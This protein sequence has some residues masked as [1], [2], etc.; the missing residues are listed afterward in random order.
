MLKAFRHILFISIMLAFGAGL[1][2]QDLPT[3]GQQA[4]ITT[5]RFANGISYYIVPNNNSKGYANFALVQKGVENQDDARAAL[6]CS[7]LASKGVGYTRLGFITYKGGAAVYNFEDVPTFQSVALDSTIIQLFNLIGA[8]KNEQAIVACGDI[9]AAKLKDR[10]YMMSLTVAKRSAPEALKP[11]VWQPS[12]TPRFIQYQNNCSSLSEILISYASPRTPQKYMSTPQPLVSTMFSRELGYIVR[13]R[14][15]RIFYNEGIPLA[16]IRF[17]YVDS[18]NTDSD[19]QY[20]ITVGVSEEDVT[21]ATALISSTLAD[22]DKNGVSPDEFLD[23]KGRVMLWTQ[24]M[25]STPVE[26]AEYTRRCVANYLY[27]ASL[28]SQKEMKVFF[29]GRKIALEQDLSMFNRFV[30]ALLDPRRNLT[31]RYGTPTETLDIP[32]LQ[33]VF[34]NSWT[35]SATSGS[36]RVSAGD[37]LSLYYPVDKKVKLKSETDDLV[38]GGKLWTFSNG[39]KVLFRKTSES[40]MRYA[41]MIRGGFTEVPDL[42]RGESAFVGDMLGLYD[43]CGMSAI[44]FRNMLEANGIELSCKVSVS[45]MRISGNAP[46][47]KVHLLLRSLLSIQKNRTLNKESYAYYKRCAF[48]KQ[49]AFRL[50]SDGIRAVTDSI[51]CPDYYYPQTKLAIEPGDSLPDNSELYFA[52]QFGKNQD[53][54]LYIEGNINPYSLQ[55]HLCKTLGGFRAGKE[56]AVRPKITYQLRSGWSTYTVA[57]NESSIGEGTSASIAMAAVRPFTIQSWFAFRLA[58]ENLRRELVRDLAPLGQYIEIV[59]ELRLLPVERLSVFIYCRPCPWEGLPAD[60]EAADPMEVMGALRESLA[61]ITSV[62]IQESTLK[63]LKDAL[64]NEIAGEISDSDYI[65][66]AFLRRNS[67]GKDMISNY[68]TYISKVTPEEVASVTADLARG[69]K[70]EYI[71]K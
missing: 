38:T 40:Q 51:M 58:V 11:Y 37:T 55:K 64:L 3:L 5:G 33:R 49:E 56:Y 63:G 7:F 68:S 70:V 8:C 16:H 4:G 69:C 6:D 24:K 32:E 26:N 36:Y 42:G 46:S 53:G 47:D 19:E 44:D 45:D 13:K 1:Y 30:S 61:R 59:P 48:L 17:S 35:A 54:V 52:R 67:E 29:D 15:E 27:G 71:I 43:V 66:E 60:A 34:L 10:L 41:L 20:S 21:A 28:A 2:A 14:L 25:A 57:G 12:D 65:M 62:T 23:A 22:I 50:S 39:M 9:D 31:V 18:A